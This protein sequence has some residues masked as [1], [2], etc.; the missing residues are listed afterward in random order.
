[1]NNIRRL[2][3]FRL[4][5]AK[6]IFTV[7]GSVLAAAVILSAVSV[8]IFAQGPGDRVT[9]VYDDG[10]LLNDSEEI[11]LET[12]EKKISEKWDVNVLI[13]TTISKTGYSNSD[14]GSESYAED[15]YHDKTD[16]HKTEEDASG[17]LIL[18]DMENRYCNIFV[19]ESVYDRVSLNR[20]VEITQDMGDYLHADNYYEALNQGL[21]EM[22]SSL[23]DYRTKQLAICWS[24]RIGGPIIVTGVLILILVYHKRSKVTVTNKTYLDSANCEVIDDIDD[25]THSTVSVVHNSSSSGG[26]GGGGGGGG[27]G[28]S[29]SG[30]SHF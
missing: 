26:H 21:S 6:R 15:I 2:P 1:M 14:S 24:I 22:D 9:G 25:F 4:S 23:Q 20:C 17:F 18:I 16:A 8:P 7:L 27:G 5:S 19:H 12:L 10:L 3:S 28:H 30:G 29:G 11:A 13:A